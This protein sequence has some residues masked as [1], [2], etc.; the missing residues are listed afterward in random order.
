MM[1]GT[2][3]DGSYPKCQLVQTWCH[4]SRFAAIC[5]V[6]QPGSGTG[7]STYGKRLL[8]HRHRRNQLCTFPNYK[9]HQPSA[10]TIAD[11][12]SGAEA[13]SQKIEALCPQVCLSQLLRITGA[14]H[15]LSITRAATSSVDPQRCQRCRLP[16]HRCPLELSACQGRQ[17]KLTL[18]GGGIK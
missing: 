2:T 4:C 5:I 13:P 6:D 18:H 14:T 3:N 11:E 8:V 15:P 1:T 17:G 10:P 7:H 9:S 12:S 16:H